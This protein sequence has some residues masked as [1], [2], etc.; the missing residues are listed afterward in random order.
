[1]ARAIAT[2]RTG[3]S[4][5]RLWA[6]R[7]AGRKST[8]GGRVRCIRP[9]VACTLPNMTKV[10]RIHGVQSGSEPQAPLPDMAPLPNMASL[11]NT[12]LQWMRATST[13]ASRRQSG[14][15]SSPSPKPPSK[16]ATCPSAHAAYAAGTR[17]V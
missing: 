6:T 1:M 13:S 10:H 9:N 8:P 16:R 7:R 11:P 14:A 15:T 2:R 12:V 3:S 17:T 5:L 4:S